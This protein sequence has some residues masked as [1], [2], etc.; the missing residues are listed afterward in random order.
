[1]RMKHLAQSSSMVGTTAI[2][3]CVLPEIS[4][5]FGIVIQMHWTD[6][7]PPHFHARYGNDR[8]AIELITLKVLSGYLPRRAMALTLEWASMHREA[9]MEDWQLCTNGRSP[10]P[11]PPLD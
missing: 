1:M 9:L 5:F 4:R 11:I 6:H 3:W 10:N 7:N 8:C 2:A